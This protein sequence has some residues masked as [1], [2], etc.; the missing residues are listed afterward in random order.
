MNDLF[1]RMK[2]R[3][4]EVF[5][6]LEKEISFLRGAN[7]FLGLI[8][9]FMSFS[10]FFFG[11][12]PP[13]VI[14][15]SEVEGAKTVTDLNVSNQPSSHEILAFAK[16][17]TA[18]YTAFNSY[19]LA[20]DLAAAFNLM[21]AKLQNESKKALIDSGFVEKLKAA[22]IDT[23][24]EFKEAK[25]ERD[26]HEACAVSLVGVRRVTKYVDVRFK[27]EVLFRS[28]LIIRKVRRTPDAPEG[29]LVEAYREMTLNDLSGKEV[30]KP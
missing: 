8:I 6:D 1:S 26:S 30:R 23:Q 27:E 13:V 28:D 29:L 20:R 25:I 22:G 24:I 15:V 16:R 21:T 18:D 12:R 9:L 4:F 2:R 17:F 10:L 3:Y 7:I 19:T 11:M 5:G 14:R